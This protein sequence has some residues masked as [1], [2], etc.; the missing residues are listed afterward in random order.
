LEYELG[1]TRYVSIRVLRAP[2]AR[3]ATSRKEQGM[4]EEEDLLLGEAYF[5]I[6][7]ILGYP[8]LFKA[9]RLPKGGM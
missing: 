4:D 6:G 9:K 3:N 5:E 1:T 2:A 7:E 8:K